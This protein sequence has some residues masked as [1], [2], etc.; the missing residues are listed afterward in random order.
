MRVRVK[1]RV[2]ATIGKLARGELG[3]FVKGSMC[4]QGCFGVRQVG[5]EEYKVKSQ[6]VKADT[7]WETVSAY[8]TAGRYVRQRKLARHVQGY[9]NGGNISHMGHGATQ[10]SKPL[11][12]SDRVDTEAP[13]EVK[14]CLASELFDWPIPCRLLGQ[15]AEMQLDTTS[16]TDQ[17]QLC[18]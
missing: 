12:A 17:F 15:K 18:G 1:V 10:A 5:D 11:R 2:R 14:I 3:R 16:P 8:T 4:E 6:T 9:L 13:E 7:M